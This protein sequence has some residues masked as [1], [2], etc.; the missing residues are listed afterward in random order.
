M[1]TRS[2]TRRASLS[3]PIPTSRTGCTPVGSDADPTLH[4]YLEP[5]ARESST[6]ASA[7]QADLYCGRRRNRVPRHHPSG[8]Y[9][10]VT[11]HVELLE[12]QA[13]CRQR[14]T[15]CSQISTLSPHW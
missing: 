9:S 15:R 1:T 5:C 11:S 13:L 10:R 7:D 6:A 3:S 2:T 8:Q 12:D 4:S 14:P